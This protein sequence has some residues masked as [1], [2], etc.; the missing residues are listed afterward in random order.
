MEQVA[1]KLDEGGVAFSVS[2][3]M[4]EEACV[5]L[6]SDSAE[7]SAMMGTPGR[8]EFISAHKDVFFPFPNRRSMSTAPNSWEINILKASRGLSVRI[9]LYPAPFK[10]AT[11]SSR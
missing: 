3:R 4:V 8:M 9:T 6:V 10:A 11:R 1:E 7:R 5:P 2:K